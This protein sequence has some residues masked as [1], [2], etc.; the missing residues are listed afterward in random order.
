MTPT[1]QDNELRN[2][3]SDVMADL[4][5]DVSL[6]KLSK[7][8][9]DIFKKGRQYIKSHNSRLNLIMQL[10]NAD[11]ERRAL[12]A[13]IDSL[14]TAKRRIYETDAFELGIYLGI[15]D[16][17]LKKLGWTPGELK[18]K[19]EQPMTN[20]S[21]PYSTHVDNENNQSELEQKIFSLTVE[22]GRKFMK[23]RVLED[24]TLSKQIMELVNDYITA[25]YTPNSEVV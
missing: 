9:G 1:D 7:N 14:L 20:Q 8:D 24:W 3:I 21:K 18:A 17:E 11:R 13:R 12:E 4:M 5:V 10:I 25:N 6:K 22:T 19:Q 15:I 23:T 16:S 2:L